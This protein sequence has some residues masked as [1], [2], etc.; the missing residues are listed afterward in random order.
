MACS[1]V[2][3]L[4]LI[5]GCGSLYLLITA[6]G[7]SALNMTVLYLFYVFMYVCIYL[8]IYHSLREVV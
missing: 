8:F 4:Y 5:S 1:K 2:S 6:A 3:L 7:E